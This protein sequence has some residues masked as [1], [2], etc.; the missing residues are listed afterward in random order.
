MTVFS[1]TDTSLLGRW[2]W[3]VDRL[4]LTA[5]LLLLAV[6]SI[7]VTA[8][9]PPVAK[10]LDLPAF[11]FVH[12]H[13]PFLLM[14]LSAMLFVS[15]LPQ[16]VVRP[17]FEPGEVADDPAHGVRL[18]MRAPVGLGLGDAAE[19]A[20]QQAPHLLVHLVQ[21]LDLGLHTTSSIGLRK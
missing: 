14:G 15:L 6:G 11:Y 12:R 17:L 8:G 19:V 16:R 10:R 20:H 4:N 9:S 2:W 13:Q 21:Q 3:T 5:L 7:L 1:R 18:R